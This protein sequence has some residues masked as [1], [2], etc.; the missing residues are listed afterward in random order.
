MKNLTLLIGMI[1]VFSSCY[2]INEDISEITF[3][4][5][6]VTS[7][8]SLIGDWLEIDPRRYITYSNDSI[9]NQP[10]LSDS[11]IL[12]FLSSGE[13]YTENEQILGIGKKGTWSIDTLDANKILIES[14]HTTL[15]A[16]NLTTDSRYF[17]IISL[18]NDT[19]K[20]DYFL[21]HKNNSTGEGFNK[22]TNRRFV[23]L[24]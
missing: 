3:N 7:S 4:S 9:P 17:E 14:E 18:T 24:N 20:V 23:R 16:L 22:R 21:H 13:Y 1:L 2:K 11:T 8:S 10:I 5:P 12:Q 19:L 15:T 6:R